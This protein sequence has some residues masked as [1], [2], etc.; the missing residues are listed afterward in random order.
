MGKL[1]SGK[2]ELELVKA[3]YNR[4]KRDIIIIPGKIERIDEK[5]VRGVGLLKIVTNPHN[6]NVAINGKRVGLSPYDF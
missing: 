6:A 3:N 5:L 4:I 2:H 1:T